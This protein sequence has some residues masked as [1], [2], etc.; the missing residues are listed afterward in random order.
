MT[1]TCH[2][3]NWESLN[4][5]HK[6]WAEKAADKHQHLYHS[7]QPNIIAIKEVRA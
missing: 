3:C 5:A 4:Y 7:G 1:A 2:T 6:G